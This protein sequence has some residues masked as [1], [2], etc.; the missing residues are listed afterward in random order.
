MAVTLGCEAGNYRRWVLDCSVTSIG[1]LWLDIWRP[2]EA[3]PMSFAVGNSAAKI[4]AL[5]AAE[6]S[7]DYTTS[8]MQVLAQLG[9]EEE[10]IAAL[11][12]LKESPMS[13]TLVEQ[14][15]G[16]GA[17]LMR[18]HPTYEVNTLTTRST[19]HNCRSWFHPSQLDKQERRLRLVLENL[20]WADKQVDKCGARDAFLKLLVCKWKGSLRDLGHSGLAIRK[21]CFSR[22]GVLFQ[23]LHPAQ[24]EVCQIRPGISP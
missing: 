2:L 9:Y 23:Q 19:V 12:L 6:P 14:A 15:H 21:A 10:V 7:G 11:N 4:E 5:K 24:R 20:E 18:R 3:G 1:Y 17:Q 8:K 16:S 13:T 22:H